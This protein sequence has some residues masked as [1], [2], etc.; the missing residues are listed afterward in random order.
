MF[1]RNSINVHSN[2]RPHLALQKLEPAGRICNFGNFFNGLAKSP[3][4][5]RS[6]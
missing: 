3:R 6:S 2:T 4:M 1:K 5:L